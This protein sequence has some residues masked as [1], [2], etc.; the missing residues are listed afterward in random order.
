MGGHAA[1]PLA[2]IRKEYKRK[3]SHVCLATGTF[4]AKLLLTLLLPCPAV[5]SASAQELTSTA[6]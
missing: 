5:S 1:F 6:R 3:W 2:E 4:T